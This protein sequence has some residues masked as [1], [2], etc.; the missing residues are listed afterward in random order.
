VRLEGLRHLSGPNVFTVKPV[1]VARIELDELTCRQTTDYPGFAGR[2]TAALPGLAD[3]HCAAGHPGGFAEAMARGTYFGHVTE[4]V[5]LELSSLAG[6]EVYLG[7]TMWAGADGR[8]DLMMECPQDE[9]AESE[10]PAELIKIA[11]MAIQDLLSERTPELTS[12]MARLARVVER[13]RLGVSTAALAAAARSRGIPVRR[14]GS[15]S[16]LRLGYGRHRRLVCAAL[17]QQ[18][19]VIGVDIAAD[20]ML[21]KQLLTD[22]GIPVPEGVVAWSAEEATAALDQLGGPAVVKPRTG[23][24]VY[25]A[26]GGPVIVD[27]GH[28][29]AALNATGRMI[30]H[31]WGGHPTAAVT[32]PGDRRDDLIIRTAEVIAAWFG[33]VI[34]YEDADRRGRAPGEMTNIITTAMRRARPDISCAAADGP[35]EALRAAVADAAGQPVLFLYEKLTLARE[36]LDAI[37]ARPW[38]AAPADSLASPDGPDGPGRPVVSAESPTR[39]EGSPAR[40][41]PTTSGDSS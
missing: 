22:A 16:M 38:P 29:A 41:A 5:A 39:A 40:P 20:K 28:N 7:R 32:L 17:T 3:H 18:T 12:D 37:G 34:V 33:R 21:A 9:P 15:L 19:S 2:L 6:R 26:A 13:E 1:S 24:H 10:V 4:H 31:V 27:Y 36:A 35:R 23:S 11:M 14:V 25:L 8:Y 30:S